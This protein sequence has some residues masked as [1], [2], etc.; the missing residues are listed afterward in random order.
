MMWRASD[1]GMPPNEIFHLERRHR[2][3]LPATFH[4]FTVHLRCLAPQ[5]WVLRERMAAKRK[6]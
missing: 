5:I 2:G 3:L 4:F 1:Y 6:K